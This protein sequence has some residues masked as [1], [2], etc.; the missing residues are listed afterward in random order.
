MGW[1]VLEM[2]WA[3]KPSMLPLLATLDI[4]GKAS[5]QA[6]CPRPLSGCPWVFLG[7]SPWGPLGLHSVIHNLA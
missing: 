1:I 4:P 5:S 7:L 3:A 2:L 6:F